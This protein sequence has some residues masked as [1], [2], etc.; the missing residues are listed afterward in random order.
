[1]GE[2]PKRIKRLAWYES[3]GPNGVWCMDQN[4]A[5]Q[6]W[7]I[8]TFR[9]L[10]G[11]SREPVACNVTTSLSGGAHSAIFGGVVQQ[12]HMLPRIL[13]VDKTSKCGN[14]KAA[15]ICFCC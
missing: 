7:R 12:L 6:R 14:E 11:F 3:Y 2:A 4:E 10:D 5:L 9:I 1:M 8:F 13:S 15:L